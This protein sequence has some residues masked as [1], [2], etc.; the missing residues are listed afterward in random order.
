MGD[1]RRSPPAEAGRPGVPA[2]AGTP[3]ATVADAVRRSVTASLGAALPAGGAVVVALSGG[4]DS[5]ALLDAALAVAAECRTPVGAIHVHHGLSANADAWARFCRATCA[6]RGVPL[7]VCT[8]DVA[9]EPRTSIE[10]AARD[11]RYAALAPAAIRH[12]ALAVLLAHHADDQAETM[13]LQ[14]LRGAGPRGLA[15]MPAARFAEGLWWLRPLL[16]LPRTLLDDYVTQHALRY[17]DDDSNLDLRHR[18]NALRNLVIPS[19][20]AVAPGYPATLVRAAGHQAEAARLADELAEHDARGAFDGATL[21]C[22]ALAALAP[23]R[24]RNLLRWFIRGQRLAVPSSAR[25]SDIVAQLTAGRQDARVTIAHAGSVLGVH[26]GRVV[27]HGPPPRRFERAWTGAERVELPHGTLALRPTQGR[28]IAARHL[29]MASNVTIRSG[30]PG[31]RLRLAGRSTRR[32]VADLLREAGV[33][34]WDRLGMPRVYCG[35]S[36][37]AVA[38]LGTDAAFA[39]APDE[40]AFTIDWQPQPVRD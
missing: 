7:T 21:D 38:P 15:G 6:A 28:G 2:G 27:V 39:A 36:L 11:A 8:V 14:L 37:A 30:A 23:H 16:A 12:R 5:I 1:T 34:A 31:E 20:R 22:G 10:A 29:F 3:V 17:V 35:G 13:L 4:R 24:A 18:R 40:T 32:S 26:H 25:L 33:P 9:R 19:L